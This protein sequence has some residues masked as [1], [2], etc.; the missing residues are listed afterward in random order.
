MLKGKPLAS[1][2]AVWVRD[3]MTASQSRSPAHTVMDGSQDTEMKSRIFAK[4]RESS[5]VS[6]EY[7]DSYW[8][9]TGN[10]KAFWRNS[11]MKCKH[12]Y[13]WKEAKIKLCN[14][15]FFKKIILS[16][17]I[18]TIQ[19]HKHRGFCFHCP[20]LPHHCFPLNHCSGTA[21]ITSPSFCLWSVFW[22]RR[23]GEQQSQVS[24]ESSV[25]S[26]SRWLC[27][28]TCLPKW[29]LIKQEF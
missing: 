15:Y 3:N 17:V 2:P 29:L 28:Y 21:T 24:W 19:F 22:Q 11:I 20:V 27:V 18:F 8:Y 5:S 23:Y 16:F 6:V 26:S 13:I 7:S 25:C 12:S 9:N 10:S 14:I 1:S 4:T